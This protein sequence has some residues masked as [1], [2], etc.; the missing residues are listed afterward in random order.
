MLEGSNEG[1]SRGNA[2][3]LATLLVAVM[4]GLTASMLAYILARNRSSNER[5]LIERRTRAAD[6]AL[7]IKIIKLMRF[8]DRSL[9][10]TFTDGTRYAVVVREHPRGDLFKLTAAARLPDDDTVAT[11]E[12]VVERVIAA[13]QSAFAGAVQTKKSVDVSGGAEING[14]NHNLDEELTRLGF[15]ATSEHDKPAVV[16]KGTITISGSSETAGG[17]DFDG[18]GNP[19]FW[20]K[21]DTNQSNDNIEDGVHRGD[22]NNINI[23]DAKQNLF[24][25]ADKALNAA[26]GIW[27]N[28]PDDHFPT[29]PDQALDSPDGTAKARAQE[30]GT[31]FTTETQFNNW[32]SSQP[33]DPITNKRMAPPNTLIYCDFKSNGSLSFDGLDWGRTYHTII[34]H[35]P[36]VPEVIKPKGGV[37]GATATAY[38]D[39]DGD[40][41]PDARDVSNECADSSHGS[42]VGSRIGSVTHGE[43]PD[44]H[45][46]GAAKWDGFGYVKIEPDGDSSVNAPHI[47][48][49]GVFILDDMSLLNSQSNIFGGICLLIK[50]TNGAKQSLSNGTA[51]VRYSAKAIDRAIAAN[52]YTGTT[53]KTRSFRT[54][55][56]TRDA[57]LAAALCGVTISIS[58]P[59]DAI[60]QS[61]T[62]RTIDGWREPANPTVS[63]AQTP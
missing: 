34:N 35:H 3:V 36:I 19:R 45:M 55:P 12:L 48:F 50:D 58:N 41:T 42:Y 37:T 62:A 26:G 31:Y 51:R 21:N 40:G 38:V 25:N 28:L 20:D 46:P 49:F 24:P 52:L 1:R 14:N 30:M 9:F 10:G 60:N 15:G 13:G 8:H 11:A 33:V 6:S 61:N 43:G 23:L 59:E 56:K 22:D 29:T 47:K 39:S 54:L 18:S 2:L 32:V 4:A 7:G 63:A 44:G 27:G 16:C 5:G 53:A 17:G 57:Q